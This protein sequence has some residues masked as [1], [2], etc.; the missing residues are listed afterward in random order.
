ME[1]K[2]ARVIGQAA[3]GVPIWRSQTLESKWVDVPYVVFP[4][5]VGHNELLGELVSSYRLS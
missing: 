1:I 5:N 4:G 2:L 3:A